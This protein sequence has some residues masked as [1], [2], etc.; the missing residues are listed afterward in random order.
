MNRPHP[1]LDTEQRQQLYGVC[2][3]AYREAGPGVGRVR[4]AKAA[5]R[6][7]LVGFS[8][9]DIMIQLAVAIAAK[10]IVDWIKGSVSEPPAAMPVGF[11]TGP[12]ED[13]GDDDPV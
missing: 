9:Q 2:R 13:V 3:D 11:G 12:V 7:R 1:Q 5:V 10:L 8:W 4:R 6:E